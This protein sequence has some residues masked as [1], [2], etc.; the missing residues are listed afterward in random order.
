MTTIQPSGAPI[1]GTLGDYVP[2]RKRLENAL[3][4]GFGITLA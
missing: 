1:E 3:G 2:F 4:S